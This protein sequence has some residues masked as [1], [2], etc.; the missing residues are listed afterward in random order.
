MLHAPAALPAARDSVSGGETAAV[1]QVAWLA[2]AVELVDAV[3]ADDIDEFYPDGKA[4]EWTLGLYTG[5]GAL[6]LSL[7]AKPEWADAP[8]DVRFGETP[9]TTVVPVVAE[10]ESIRVVTVNYEPDEGEGFGGNIASA[11]SSLRTHFERER[12]DLLTRQ[13]NHSVT[14]LLGHTHTDRMITDQRWYAH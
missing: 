2:N 4:G 11:R 7:A 12:F 1:S 14:A 5:F 3:T 13:L 10:I 6:I 8:V 9:I